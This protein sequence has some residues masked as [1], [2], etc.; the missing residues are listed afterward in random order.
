[1]K[2]EERRYTDKNGIEHFCCDYYSNAKT[3][4]QAACKAVGSKYKEDVEQWI[5]TDCLTIQD[6]GTEGKWYVCWCD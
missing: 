2:Y 5:G 4:W 3:M 6:G 1:M